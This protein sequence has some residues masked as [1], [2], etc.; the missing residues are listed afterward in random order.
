[1]ASTWFLYRMDLI[2][3]MALLLCNCVVFHMH[4]NTS[5]RCVSF[6]HNKI[7]L[8]QLRIG[9]RM[10]EGG[11][12]IIVRMLTLIQ[13]FFDQNYR[14]HIRG[15]QRDGSLQG[16]KHRQ[17]MSAI[18]PHRTPQHTLVWYLYQANNNNNYLYLYNIKHMSLCVRKTTISVPTKS[19]TAKEAC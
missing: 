5:I 15:C 13:R 11:G 3:G 1:M 12:G 2:I 19:C 6:K 7:N 4:K 17:L 18:D 16:P 9:L 10:T 14:P 8:L